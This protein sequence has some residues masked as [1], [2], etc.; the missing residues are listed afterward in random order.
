MYIYAYTGKP[1]DF[2]RVKKALVKVCNTSWGI[3][4]AVLL[5]QNMFIVR[6]G[7]DLPTEV[8]L[9]LNTLLSN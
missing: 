5:R 4:F 3:P 6:Y 9:V 1:H 7:L 2:S 8:R